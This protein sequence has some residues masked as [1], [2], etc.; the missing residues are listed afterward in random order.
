MAST[1]KPLGEMSIT[2]SQAADLDRI[3]RRA[4]KRSADL[5][6]DTDDAD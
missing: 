4:E 3:R 6:N 5:V 1:K 2:N